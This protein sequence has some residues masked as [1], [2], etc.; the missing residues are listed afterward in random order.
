[1]V[2]II[3]NPG[4]VFE[5]ED[6]M[7]RL[8]P[9]R[10]WRIISLVLLMLSIVFTLTGT[11]FIQGEIVIHWNSSGEPDGSAGK[12]ILWA[13]LLLAFLSLFTHTS[14]S[15]KRPGSNPLS[16]EMSCALSSGLVMIWTVTEMIL[17]IYHFY[18][19]KSLS[20]I[21]LSIIICGFFA[22]FM[23]ACIRRRKRKILYAGIAAAGAVVLLVIVFIIKAVNYES[24]SYGSVEKDIPLEA[25]SQD[26]NTLYTEVSGKCASYTKDHTLVRIEG[27]YTRNQAD[28]K[29]DY[30]EIV[31]I[32]YQYIDEN[33]EGG[34]LSVVEAEINM[35]ANTL[36]IRRF[37]GAGK[38]YGGFLGSEEIKT[39]ELDVLTDSI[40]NNPD[41]KDSGYFTSRIGRDG[42]LV[43]Y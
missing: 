28:D 10:L 9:V 7:F 16:E 29:V 31:F 38:A 34:R 17:V 27:A 2:E 19:S 5:E 25:V 8:P 11:F 36:N 24:Y 12:W 13:L 22:F 40:Q 41:M 30:S 18:P 37:Y 15:K 23:L 26:W 43:V 4:G 21:G 33:A 20:S 14:L 35:P 1:M 39:D 3:L 6:E 32:F 42:E